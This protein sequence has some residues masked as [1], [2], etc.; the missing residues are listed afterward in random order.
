MTVKFTTAASPY[1]ILVGLLCGSHSIYHSA[2]RSYSYHYLTGNTTY[3]RTFSFDAGFEQS[4]PWRVLNHLTSAPVLDGTELGWLSP[5]VQEHSAIAVYQTR[6]LSYAHTEPLR[7]F[8]VIPHPERDLDELVFQFLTEPIPPVSIGI[9]YLVNRQPGE[10]VMDIRHLDPADL[11]V[12]SIR[13]GWPPVDGDDHSYHL[14]ALSPLLFLRI[15]YPSRL[16]LLWDFP[17]SGFNLSQ[18][19]QDGTGAVV[20]KFEHPERPS[21]LVLKYTDTNRDSDACIHRNRALFADA[22]AMHSALMGYTGLSEHELA[23][24]ILLWWS[25][26]CGQYARLLST[27][28][29]RRTSALLLSDMVRRVGDHTMLEPLLERVMRR[30]QKLFTDTAITELGAPHPRRYSFPVPTNMTSLDHHL[31]LKTW[32]LLR[33]QLGQEPVRKHNYLEVTRHAG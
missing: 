25:V 32:N 8:C 12:S 20:L 30:K 27:A 28:A 18:I 19:I 1:E 24:L 16:D 13:L 9:G 22:I 26:A 10:H 3:Y 15:A 17:T 29:C 21:A 7:Q 4:D 6:A 14:L 5:P 11:E 33:S 23:F 31:L 2:E